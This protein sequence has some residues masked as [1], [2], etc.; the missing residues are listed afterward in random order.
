[1]PASDMTKENIQDEIEEVVPKLLDMALF[2]V[3]SL[4]SSSVRGIYWL[5]LLLYQV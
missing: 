3:A 4:F 1:M 2:T 5:A